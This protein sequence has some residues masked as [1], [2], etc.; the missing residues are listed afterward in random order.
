MYSI[1]IYIY[2]YIYIL[3]ISCM[4]EPQNCCDKLAIIK[5]KS[6]LLSESFHKMT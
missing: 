1:Y 5:F 4:Y 2:I 3:T 6:Q